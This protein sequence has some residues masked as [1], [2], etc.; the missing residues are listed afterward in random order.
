METGHAHGYY[1]NV[2][3]ETELTRKKVEELPPQ[4]SMAGFALPFAPIPRLAEN[5]LVRHRPGYRR[6]RN[7]QDQQ[8]EQL[9]S[10]AWYVFF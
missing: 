7:R 1:C 3:A 9:R 2:E 6:D 5:L 4:K 8:L 10:N